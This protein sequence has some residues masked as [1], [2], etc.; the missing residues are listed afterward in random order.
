MIDSFRHRPDEK[1]S[2]SVDWR[3]PASNQETKKVIPHRRR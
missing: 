3:T 2:R 1:R